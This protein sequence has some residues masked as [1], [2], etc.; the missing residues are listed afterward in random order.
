MEHVAVACVSPVA[1]DACFAIEGH[2]DND[3]LVLDRW[4][5]ENEIGV[6]RLKISIREH[7]FLL[8]EIGIQ[9]EEID[10]GHGLIFSRVARGTFAL[11]GQDQSMGTIRRFF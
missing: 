6:F 8:E 1:I 7:G 4:W 11:S 10:A 9:T 2:I 3:F 5:Q